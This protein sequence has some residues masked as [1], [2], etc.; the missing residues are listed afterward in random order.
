MAKLSA[1]AVVA[2][3]CCCCVLLAAKPAA[4]NDGGFFETTVFELVN[5]AIRGNSTVG[6]G[7][8]RIGPALIRLLLHDCW[9][10]VRHTYTYAI[11]L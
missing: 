8:P 9:V 3:L 2:S 10:N 4:A 11:L 6:G 7:D 5:A 1:A